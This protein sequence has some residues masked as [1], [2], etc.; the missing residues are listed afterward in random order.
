MEWGRE[1]TPT[2]CPPRAGQL[3]CADPF[4]SRERPAWLV[5]STSRCRG[6]E[7][8]GAGF[9]KMVGVTVTRRL[10]PRLCTGVRTRQTGVCKGRQGRGATRWCRPEAA[11]PSLPRARSRLH[12]ERD[13]A[14]GFG[15]DG[16]TGFFLS[17]S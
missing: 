8:L 6:S 14:V 4:N 3:M 12:T 16:L 10:P 7:K 1:E 5:L 17:T 9:R 13:T 15:G 11:T 2:R